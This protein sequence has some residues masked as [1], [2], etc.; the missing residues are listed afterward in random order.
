MTAAL[1]HPMAGGYAAQPYSQ[2]RPALALVV[3]VH[4]CCIFA[5]ARLIDAH[6]IPLREPLI[7]ELLETPRPEIEKPP[8]KKKPPEPKVEE[9]PAP[10]EKPPQPKAEVPPPPEQPVLKP[11]VPP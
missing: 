7:V 9:P 10:L 1:M 11:D 3:I 8:P 5:L 4:A 2:S 6:R